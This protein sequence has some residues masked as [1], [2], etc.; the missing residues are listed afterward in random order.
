MSDPCLISFWFMRIFELLQGR[1]PKG[2]FR[3]R[4]ALD[5]ARGCKRSANS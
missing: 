1:N 5:Q 3:F 4:L 2:V